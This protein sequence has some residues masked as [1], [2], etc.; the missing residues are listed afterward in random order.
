MI[1]KRKKITILI[2]T[3]PALLIL[4]VLYANGILKVA[5]Y[6]TTKYQSFEYNRDSYD[7]NYY[8]KLNDAE[9]ISFGINNLETRNINKKAQL[10]GLLKITFSEIFSDVQYVYYWDLR[11]WI[12][13]LTLTKSDNLKRIGIH[14][15]IP[16]DLR[17]KEVELKIEAINEVTIPGD[18][19]MFFIDIPSKSYEKQYLNKQMKN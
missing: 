3:F 1:N 11:M 9:V 5:S 8:I 10:N 4:T 2:C 13:F 17:N 12:D 6:F 19:Y 16:E 18:L 7:H 14:L 15:E